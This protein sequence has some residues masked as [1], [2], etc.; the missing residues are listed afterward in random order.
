MKKTYISPKTHIVKI[1]SKASI[2]QMSDFNEQ[3]DTTGADGSK[4]LVK[5][6]PISNYNV[7]DD[8]WSN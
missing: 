8:D 5:E 2:L 1:H 3:L 7:W 6:N 4:A